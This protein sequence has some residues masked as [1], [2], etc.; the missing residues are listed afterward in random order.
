MSIGTGPYLGAFNEAYLRSGELARRQQRTDLEEAMTLEGLRQQAQ[1][2][3]DMGILANA[4][5]ARRRALAAAP[6]APGM[7]PTVAPPPGPEQ[8]AG[9]P[10]VSAL[11]QAPPVAPSPPVGAPAGE[12]LRRQGLLEAL[13][14][15]VA[16]R[17]L[18]SRSGRGAIKDLE[19]AE[20]EHETQENRRKAEEIWT[21]ATTAMKAGDVQTYYDNAAKAMRMVGNHEAAAKYLEHAMTLRGDEKEL[22]SA[23]EDLGR[24]LKA[25]GKYANDPSPENYAAFLEELGQ[26][27]SK[28]SRAIRVQLAT[29]VITKTFNQNPKV[30]AFSRAVAS[31]YR[32]AFSGG[33]EPDAEKIFK[34][35]AAADPEGFNAYVYDALANQKQ[36]PEVVL[37]KV[38]RWNV[39][40]AKEIPKDVWSFSFART[41][42]RL[43]GLRPDDPKFMEA[44]QQELVATAKRMK[45]A[46]RKP[47][48]DEKET[49]ANISELRRRLNDVRAELRRNPDMADTDPERYR[50]LRGEEKQSVEDLKWHEERLRK[51]SGAPPAKQQPADIPVNPPAPKLK[52]GDDKY[53]AAAKAEMSR[54]SQAGYTREQTI[55]RMRKAGW[56]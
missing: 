30:T 25:Q 10:P 19:D 40:D 42:A 32:D 43:P 33:Q 11:A 3:A 1:E 45:D 29:N 24:W 54:L 53:R 18:R 5:Q 35:A 12:G 2:S 38:L 31:A 44:W 8:L 41:K 9:P 6:G 22:S 28:T 7:P 56:Q 27:N 48:D 26:A 46:E 20:K 16:G 13:S 51:T 15:D 55:E 52:P 39:V 14:P 49:R 47:A 17:I 37:K 23:N 34:A 21:E 50:D 4:Y 36:L